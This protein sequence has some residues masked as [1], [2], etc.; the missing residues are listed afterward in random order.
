MKDHL[1]YLETGE[2]G[3]KRKK[4][5]EKEKYLNDVRWKGT[6][7]TVHWDIKPTKDF[8][9]DMDVVGNFKILQKTSHLTNI[10]VIDENDY[11]RKYNCPEALLYDFCP[12]RL[13]YYDRRR[14]YWLEELGKDHAK[15]SGR[16]KYVK[17]VVDKK[18]NMYQEDADLER[19]MI[20]LGLKKVGCKEN[21]DGEVKESFD[22]LLSMQM[23]SMTMKK[24]EEIKKEVEKIKAKIDEL[25]GKT[26]KDLWKEDLVSFRA[27]YAK[28]LKTRKE[29]SDCK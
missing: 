8:I 12:V 17:A 13:E 28:F 16:Y 9:P 14:D 23:R 11:P 6:T 24:L 26:S 4:G 22:Y 25:E 19:D 29:E 18:L 10:H 27:A 20:K 3:K 7:N 2:G 21:K 1:S 15:E 5:A